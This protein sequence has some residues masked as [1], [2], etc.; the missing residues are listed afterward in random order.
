[1][2]IALIII[3]SFTLGIKFIVLKHLIKLRDL[4]PERKSYYEQR[5]I[6]AKMLI[7]PTIV[8]LSSALIFKYWK[9]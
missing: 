4:Y 2:L 1:M 8:L 6:V 3:F 7:M 5:I 9:G